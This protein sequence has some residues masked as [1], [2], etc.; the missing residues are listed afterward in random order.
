[1]SPEAVWTA[2]NISPVVSTNGTAAEERVQFKF[3][4]TGFFAVHQQA[5]WP[6]EKEAWPED[7]GD[8]VIVVPNS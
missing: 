3:I 5:L 6:L 7:L 2:L 1:M 8:H 4:A